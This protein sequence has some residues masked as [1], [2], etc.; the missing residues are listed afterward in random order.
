MI[1]LSRQLTV[2]SV[3]DIKVG[4]TVP[5]TV[6]PTLRLLIHEGTRMSRRCLQVCETGKA[7]ACS[8]MGQLVATNRGTAE[9]K[10]SPPSPGLQISFGP[11]LDVKFGRRALLSV[12]ASPVIFMGGSILLGIAGWNFWPIL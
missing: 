4:P 8:T 3:F 5:C 12:Y 7:V 1:G 2:G 11:G 6:G 10:Q 9:S